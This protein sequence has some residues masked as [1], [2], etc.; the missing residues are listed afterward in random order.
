M[1]HR[2]YMMLHRTRTFFRILMTE[3]EENI[4]SLFIL[5]VLMWI[6]FVIGIG[7]AFEFTLKN[8]MIGSVLSIIT[9]SFM[10]A[11]LMGVMKDWENKRYITLFNFWWRPFC[12]KM[13]IECRNSDHR[14]DMIY[15]CADNCRGPF[16]NVQG[17][18]EWCFLFSSDVMAFKMMWEEEDSQ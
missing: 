2:I 13:Y 17:T 4:T 10:T 12:T 1:L 18:N 6:P 7:V 5:F 16:C 8:F 3:Y 14:M 15:W 11:I 9:F